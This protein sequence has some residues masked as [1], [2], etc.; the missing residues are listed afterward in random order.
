MSAS[1]ANATSGNVNRLY[2]WGPLSAF[3][4]TVAAITGIVDQASKFWLLFGLHID[5]LGPVAVTPFLDLALTWNTGISYGAFP[6]QGPVGPWTLLAF[7]IAAVVFLWVCLSR[8]RS[9]L[10]A[11]ALGLM[12]GGAVGNSIDRLH[13]PGNM[14]F[15]LLHVEIAGRTY[16]SY[17]F[18]LADVAIVV[19]LC[20]IIYALLRTFPTRPNGDASLPLTE[21]LRLKQLDE[22]N[23][24]LRKL[25]KN[26]SGLPY[27]MWSLIAI[28]FLVFFVQAAGG[29]DQMDQVDHFAG[30]IPA[31]F[32]GVTISGTL[33][34]PVTL[35]TSMFLHSNFM[36]V[37]GNMIFLFVFGD[38]IEEVLGHWR[39]LVF[40]LSCGVGAGLT[41][42]FSDPS[43]TTEL[44]GASGAVFGVVYA[45]SIFRP[46]AN[47]VCLRGL[48]PV[49][50][51]AYLVIGGVTALQVLMFWTKEGDA[52]WANVGGSITGAILF[53]LI[54]PPGVK[55]F[56]CVRSE[57]IAVSD[58]LEQVN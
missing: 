23:A 55:L 22:E 58:S 1:G 18:S 40:Y 44:I 39:C 20:S 41:F 48:I 43:S 25:R 4:L 53:I 46:C 17:V 30:L 27:V 3:G 33:P 8:A 14:N 47:V 57:P 26:P 31:A 24:K 5:R 6:Q 38:D 45:Y 11:W 2:T 42:V 16:R 50:I 52:H 36:H 28:N 7:K 21:V 37:F 54:R 10:M 15:V 9:W 12:I 13:W 29:S 34:A 56:D 49:C 19:G 51:K 35:I 32:T